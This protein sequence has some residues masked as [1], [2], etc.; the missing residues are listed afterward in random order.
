MRPDRG[1]EDVGALRSRRINIPLL[2]VETGV[3]KDQ[4]KVGVKVAILR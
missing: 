1:V 2:G 3:R 4:S